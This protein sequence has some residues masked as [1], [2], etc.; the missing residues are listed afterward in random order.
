[1][2]AVSDSPYIREIN[3]ITDSQGRELIVGVNYDAV[4]LR[5][6]DASVDLGSTQVEELAQAVVSATWQASWQTAVSLAR[7][8]AQPGRPS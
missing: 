5:I 6:G 1:V 2:T 8:A 4:T 7:A 3:K